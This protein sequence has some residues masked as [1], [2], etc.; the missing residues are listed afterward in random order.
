MLRH[1]D[2]YGVAL[3]ARFV[4]HESPFLQVGPSSELMTFTATATLAGCFA[5][6]DAVDTDRLRRASVAQYVA[7][8]TL[9]SICRECFLTVGT[10]DS[11]E[12]LREQEATHLC[13]KW[14]P[15]SAKSPAAI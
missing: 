11:F 14:P 2:H 1:L 10:A 3:G 12:K 9:E 4:G 8:G 15:E 5:C 6:H 13:M 7:D